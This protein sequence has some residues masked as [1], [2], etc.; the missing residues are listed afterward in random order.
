VN[1][2]RHIGQEG[3]AV[4][5]TLYNER[6][7]RHPGVPGQDR[8]QERLGISDALDGLEPEL[9]LAPGE[10]RADVRTAGWSFR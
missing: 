1:G 5:A 7:R 4:L 3:L 9:N 2:V 6:G 10:L 8:A